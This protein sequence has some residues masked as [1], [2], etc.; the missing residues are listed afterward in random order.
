M[1]RL[2]FVMKTL[3]LCTWFDGGPDMEIFAFKVLDEN[4]NV[5]ETPKYEYP[6]ILDLYHQESRYEECNVFWSAVCEVAEEYQPY[7]SKDVIEDT[8]RLN[9]A[10]DALE[11]YEDKYDEI[12]P[13]GWQYKYNK[14]YDEKHGEER[15]KLWKSAKALQDSLDEKYHGKSLGSYIRHYIGVEEFCELNNIDKVIRL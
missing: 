10:W 4:F 7:V 2:Y 1:W 6:T 5:V 9:A 13:Y 12:L 8:K 15:S 14:N 11:Q 3:V